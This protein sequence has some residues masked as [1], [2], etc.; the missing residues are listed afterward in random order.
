MEEKIPLSQEVMCFQ[1]LDSDKIKFLG[2]EIKF[3]Y[4]SGK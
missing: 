2:L 1:M 4:F 3:K